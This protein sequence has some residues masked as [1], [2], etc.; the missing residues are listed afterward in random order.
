VVL[1]LYAGTGVLGIEAWSRGASSVVFVERAPQ[2]LAALRAN[3]EALGLAAGVEV[4]RGDVARCV[5]RLGN[6]GR[7]FDLVLLDPPYES[8]ELGKALAALSEAQVVAAHG[9]LVVEHGRRHPVPR[10]AD[11]AVIDEWTYG[12]TQVTRLARA[13]ISPEEGVTLEQE[14]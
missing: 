9:T 5:R 4:L 6:A 7:R 3:L 13:G 1:D 12:E 2:V 14:S 10:T 8:E 11:W